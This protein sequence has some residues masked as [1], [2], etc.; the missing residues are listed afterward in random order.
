[1]VIGVA[2]KA[3]K[4]AA[5]FRDGN[6]GEIGRADFGDYL[7]RYSKYANSIARHH[8]PRRTL[9]VSRP[10]VLRKNYIRA[11]VALR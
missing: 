10:R 5:I 2:W 4:D 1:M 9:P 6:T 3:E 11:E 7:E 8:C